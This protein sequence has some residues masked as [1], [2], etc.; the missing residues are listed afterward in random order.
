[1]PEALTAFVR[2]TPVRL[3]ARLEQEIRA[4]PRVHSAFYK[5]ISSNAA[6]RR[7]AGSVKDRVRHSSGT[8]ATVPLVFVEP[9]V[10]TRLLRGIAARLGLERGSA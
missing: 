10:R 2:R 5:A 7:A 1:M 6:L 4:H 9:E 3:A 8:T